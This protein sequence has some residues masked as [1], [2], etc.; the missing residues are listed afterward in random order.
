MIKR[1]WNTPAIFAEFPS[2]Y[3]VLT[4]VVPFVLCLCCTLCTFYIHKLS[5]WLYK[6]CEQY[7]DVKMSIWLCVFW[8]PS[9]IMKQD[10]SIHKHLVLL[11]CV[12]FLKGKADY[13]SITALSQ[14]LPLISKRGTETHG[15]VY[16]FLAVKGPIRVQG[17]P[18]IEPGS[19][20]SQFKPPLWLMSV[21]FDWP[22]YW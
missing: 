15:D 2:S 3:M 12:L 4:S 13:A 11:L 21:I 17:K 16:N 14:L 18:G 8:I 7:K 6:Q 20:K 19:F 1:F 10:F 22:S 9:P 5:K